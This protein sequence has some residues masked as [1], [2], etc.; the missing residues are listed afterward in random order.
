MTCFNMMIDPSV[1]FSSF[2]SPISC[3]SIDMLRVITKPF[4]PSC[5]SCSYFFLK[6]YQCLGTLFKNHLQRILNLF[7]FFPCCKI[8]CKK[9]PYSILC[10]PSIFIIKHAPC[11]ISHIHLFISKL[12][13]ITITSREQPW[14][15]SCKKTIVFIIFIYWIGRGIWKLNCGIL[16][17]IVF[18]QSSIQ[19]FNDLDIFFLANEE[20]VMVKHP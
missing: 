5:V 4:K 7:D 19:C 3:R 9:A 18:I 13:K 15:G 12:T 1:Y 16:L 11:P 2:G 8:Q 20:L 10:K 6:L 17:L 14:E